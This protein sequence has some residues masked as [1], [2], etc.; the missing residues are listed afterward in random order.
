MGNK[1]RTNRNSQDNHRVDQASTL[2]SDANSDWLHEKWEHM[3]N[4]PRV[5]EVIV[6]MG[7]AGVSL[8]FLFLSL[9]TQNTNDV[10]PAI[11]LNG[12]DGLPGELINTSSRKTYPKLNLG[13]ASTKGDVDYAYV[14]RDQETPSTSSYS[15][16]NALRIFSPALPWPSPPALTVEM[17]TKSI[18]ADSTVS[19]EK[20]AALTKHL[21][22]AVVHAS[23]VLDKAGMLN[24]VRLTLG[25]P[26]HELHAR[27]MSGEGGFL[28]G[29]VSMD[30]PRTI[31][32]MRAGASI[33]ATA[34]DVLHMVFHAFGV[35]IGFLRGADGDR[36]SYFKDPDLRQKIA[37]ILCNG[38]RSVMR[39]LPD[40]LEKE[41]AGA[42]SVSE[43]QQLQ[44]YRAKLKLVRTK[45]SAS[46][47]PDE[48]LGKLIAD[49]ALETTKKGRGY[50]MV[51][52][53]ESPDDDLCDNNWLITRFEITGGKGTI[54]SRSSR[55]PVTDDPLVHFLEDIQWRFECLEARDRPR[56]QEK[57]Y[58]KG[59]VEAYV[60]EEY[61]TF[62]LQ[63][64]MVM[65][66]YPELNELLMT[67]HD[68]YQILKHNQTT[69]HAPTL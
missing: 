3:P 11:I 27:R 24:Y 14:C 62:T 66:F 26:D 52:P 59:T 69:N 44:N 20:Q 61:V 40:L 67:M 12:T 18:I 57:G 63:T 46:H 64:G 53:R 41:F 5:V 38:D 47:V 58:D 37:G 23:N 7:L 16:T 60:L 68:D 54:F 49:G 9:A 30:V 1:K 43:A 50:A 55:G 13:P 42:L 28:T 32:F 36:L 33:R 22:K 29:D 56:L 19:P 6:G 45:E 65:E 10:L 17:L 8:Y 51:A 15:N 4:Y 2:E 31:I 25:N 35:S 21:A 34:G 48:E 39:I